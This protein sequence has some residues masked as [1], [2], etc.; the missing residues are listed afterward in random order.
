MSR[1]VRIRLA[2]MALGGVLLGALLLV[3][4][5]ASADEVGIA[6]RRVGFD[7]GSM[8]GRSCR[9]RP[10]KVPAGTT[11]RLVNQTGR[12]VDFRR[13]STPARLD[14]ACELG[15][16]PQPMLATAQPTDPAAAPGPGTGP[17]GATAT[18]P[19]WP[20]GGGAPTATG[21]TSARTVR[22]RRGPR[23]PSRP[24]NRPSN[25]DRELTGPPN[26]APGRPDG[27]RPANVPAGAPGLPTTLLGDRVPPRPA[28][29]PAT[30]ATEFAGMPPSGGSALVP[31]VPVL[32]LSQLGPPGALSAVPTEPAVPSE[33]AM[34]TEAAMPSEAAVP[35]AVAGPLADSRTIGLLAMTAIV[36]LLGVVASTIRAIVSQRASR[37]TIA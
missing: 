31:G 7:A 33:A 28:H 3:D 19:A 32:G 35:L 10:M 23:R 24:P 14:P 22:P 20:G 13:G 15:D 5:T 30:A 18:S 21:A 26:R 17:S 37:T 29:G 25:R 4:G 8:I 11:L 16:E 9:S 34:P 1:Q 6:G 12:E 2:A 36:C 27:G